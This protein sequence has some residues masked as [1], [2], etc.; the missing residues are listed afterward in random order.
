M[1]LLLSRQAEDKK[2]TRGRR[3]ICGLQHSS[4]RRPAVRI[5]ASKGFA[6]PACQI[7]SK[8]PHFKPLQTTPG[9]APTCWALGR[10]CRRRRRL[11]RHCLV[12]QYLLLL[13][14]E[15]LLGSQLA[16]WRC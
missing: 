4:G 2:H 6:G 14:L 12:Y 11:R 8:T 9:A 1:C 15:H 5:A 13:R 3:G 7:S 10:C 16:A